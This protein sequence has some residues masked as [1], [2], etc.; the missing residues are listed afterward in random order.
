MEI[1]QTLLRDV[2]VVK[3]PSFS[4]HRGGFT[5]LYTHAS[6]LLEH[7]QIQQVNYVQNHQAGILRGLHY[8]TGDWAESKFFRVLQGRIQLGFVDLR[9][10]QHQPDQAATWVL[11]QPDIGVLIPRGFATGYLTLAPDTTVLYYS[12]NAYH[13]EAEQGIRWDDPAFAL[14]W[15]IQ[16]PDLSDKD[17]QW[18]FVAP[19]A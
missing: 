7:Y 6:P 8:Q 19:T 5:K 10:G 16:A 11:D 12:D 18:A 9:S 15:Q 2:H 14:P 4:D 17:A 1:I 13:P 3:S